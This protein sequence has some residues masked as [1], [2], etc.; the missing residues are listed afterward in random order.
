LSHTQYFA[1]FL[2]CKLYRQNYAQV[3]CVCHFRYSMST[4]KHSWNCTCPLPAAAC[5]DNFNFV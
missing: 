1:S 3:T 2:T 4:H 5:C